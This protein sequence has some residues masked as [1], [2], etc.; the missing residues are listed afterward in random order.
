[1]LRVLTFEKGLG[2]RLSPNVGE[3]VFIEGGLLHRRGGERHRRIRLI[4][5][6][7]IDLLDGKLR[8]DA[9]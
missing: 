2:N 8:G 7:D 5:L 9:S 4:A 6:G 3:P 1:M